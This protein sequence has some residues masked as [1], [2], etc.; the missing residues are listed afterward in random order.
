MIADAITAAVWLAGALL[1]LLAAVGVLRMPDV[2]TR[3]QTSTKASTLGM[4]FLILG[5]AVQVPD[6]ASVVKLA[7]ILAFLMLTTPVAAH[8][9]ARAAYI[10]DVPLWEATVIDERRQDDHRISDG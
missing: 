6:V 4:A 1:T 2:F 5:A 10:T 7:S 8:V 3:M 9:I